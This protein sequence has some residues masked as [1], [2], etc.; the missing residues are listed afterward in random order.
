MLDHLCADG[1]IR[2]TIAERQVLDVA[3][4]KIG[5]RNSFS[6]PIKVPSIYINA[7]DSRRPNVP[8][9]QTGPA[10]DIQREL[11]SA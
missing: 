1:K 8:G 4:N 2:K 5:V 10:A 7:N 9:N 3:L 6:C 11:T